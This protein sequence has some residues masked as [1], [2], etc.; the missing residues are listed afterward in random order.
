MKQL[1]GYILL[2]GIIR[3]FGYKGEKTGWTYFEVPATI[4]LQ[5]VPG[6]KKS[7]R[8]KGYFDEVPVKQ[9]ALLP[10][11]DG[12]FIIPL[13]ASMRKALGKREG[14]R[15][16]L[17][18]RVDRSEQVTDRDFAACL[19]DDAAARE[20]FS[21]L[22]PSHRNYFSKWIADA[23]TTQTKARR[24]AMALEALANRMDFGQMLRMRAG[25][26]TV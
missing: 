17:R 20:G 16:T 1:R 24:I 14:N 15:L 7:F 23:R 6:N 21:R 12:R 5:L 11:G 13:N 25:K 3:K 26:N 8:I 18:I 22:P 4:A 9:V 19:E 2:E 10:M